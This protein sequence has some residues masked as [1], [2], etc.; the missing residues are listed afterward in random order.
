MLLSFIYLL[1]LLNENFARKYHE[2]RKQV[3]IFCR[4]VLVSRTHDYNTVI[5]FHTINEIGNVL[6]YAQT[7]FF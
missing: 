6:K 1:Y 7:P 5:N 3:T 2:M 4:I